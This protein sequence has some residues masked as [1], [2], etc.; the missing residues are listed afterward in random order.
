[1]LRGHVRANRRQRRMP[2]LEAIWRFA[3]GTRTARRRPAW[4]R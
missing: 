2:K 1:M 3:P 4:S